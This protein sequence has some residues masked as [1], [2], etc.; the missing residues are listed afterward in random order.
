VILYNNVIV[1]KDTNVKIDL[2][3]L[4]FEDEVHCNYFS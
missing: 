4:R 3:I 2:R 1:N